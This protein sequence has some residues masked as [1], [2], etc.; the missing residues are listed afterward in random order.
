MRY[1]EKRVCGV[2][3][4][5]AL[6]CSTPYSGLSKVRRSDQPYGNFILNV[7]ISI[8]AALDKEV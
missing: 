5:P 2:D 4:A 3:S 7:Q 8:F 6:N 1:L